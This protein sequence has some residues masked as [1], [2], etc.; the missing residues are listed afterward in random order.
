MNHTALQGIGYLVKD[1]DKEVTMAT[2]GLHRA[3][4]RPRQSGRHRVPPSGRGCSA[5]ANQSP[6]PRTGTLAAASVRGVPHAKFNESCKPECAACPPPPASLAGPSWS[7][8]RSGGSSRRRWIKDI[9]A[10]SCS[11][12]RHRRPPAPRGPVAGPLPSPKCPSHCRCWPVRLPRP[13]AG[14]SWPTD[15]YSPSQCLPPPPTGG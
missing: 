12:V 13:A 3:P 9:F 4:S 14:P 6:A 5:T 15:P 2:A 8:R 11:P 10:W 1:K 7:G